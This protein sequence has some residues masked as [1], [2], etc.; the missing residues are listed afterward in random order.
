MKNDFTVSHLNHVVIPVITSLSCLT[1][2]AN[3]LES[4]SIACCVRGISISR[5]AYKR[6]FSVL[7]YIKIHAQLI[8]FCIHS[9][10]LLS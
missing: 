10:V 1:M 5:E 2:T 4:V 3:G 7:I 9:C 8:R 6:S